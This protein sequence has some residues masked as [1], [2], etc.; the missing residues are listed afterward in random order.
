MRAAA[1]IDAATVPHPAAMVAF[2]PA[3]HQLRETDKNVNRSS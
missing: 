1:V 3:D 2:R